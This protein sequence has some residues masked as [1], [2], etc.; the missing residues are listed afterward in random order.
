MAAPTPTCCPSRSRSPGR[1]ARRAL[2]AGV[3]AALVSG[4]LAGLTG[5][6]DRLPAFANP[7]PDD[8]GPDRDAASDED[9]G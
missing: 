8:A 4:A 1:E 6:D 2:G 9:A 3:L 7:P 5:C